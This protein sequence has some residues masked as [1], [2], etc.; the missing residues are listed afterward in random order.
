MNIAEPADVSAA[1]GVKP[2]SGADSNHLCF[3]LNISLAINDF[4]YLF[5]D[6]TALFKMH[7]KALDE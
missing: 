6:Q 5:T 4:E 7:N 2:S 3:Y 1:N